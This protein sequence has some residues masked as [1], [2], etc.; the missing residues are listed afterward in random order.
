MINSPS[1]ASK[2]KSTNRCMTSRWICPLFIIQSVVSSLADAVL[3]SVQVGAAVVS[4][5]R[6]GKAGMTG[7]KESLNTR[8]ASSPN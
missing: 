4:R 3:I 8:G 5:Q 1:P 6:Q 2:Q 7:R